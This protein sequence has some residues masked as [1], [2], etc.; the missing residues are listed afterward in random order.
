MTVRARKFMTDRLLPR[1]QM[2]ADVLYPNRAT[3]PRADLRKKL[4]KMYKCNPNRVGGYSSHK[5]F[6]VY[7]KR[8]PSG[9]RGG[10]GC[11]KEL[12]LGEKWFNC[13]L[14]L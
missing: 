11:G 4:A 6:C 12:H 8:I 10:K 3:V 2:V 7:I 14:I 1:R 9:R 5:K 13:L